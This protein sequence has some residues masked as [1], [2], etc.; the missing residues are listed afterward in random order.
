MLETKTL[1][2]EIE[3]VRGSKLGEI[4]KQVAIPLISILF[5]FILG[6]F[7]LMFLEYDPLVAYNKMTFKTL[8]EKRITTTLFYATPLIFTGLSVAVAFRAGMFN[9]GTE[10][11]MVIGAFF[12]ALVGFGLKNHFGIDFPDIIFILILFLAGFV[13]G[14]VWAIVPAVLKARGVHEVITTIMMNYIA[15]AL[16][17]FLVGSSESPF[18]DQGTV[19]TGNVSPQTPKIPTS[20]RLPLVF[21]RTFS[22]YLH[23]GFFIGLIVCVIIFIVMWKTKLG[24]EMRAVGYNPNAAKYGG[25]NV[26]K[27]LIIVML[28]SGGL[29]GLAGATEVIGQWFMYLDKSLAGYGFD[30]IA[31]AI[32]GGNH[33]F[34]VIFGALLFGWL[35]TAALVLQL[36]PNPI[37]KD[38][39][40]TLKGFIVLLVAVPMVSRIVIERLNIRYEGS[41][42]NNLVSSFNERYNQH[43]G[44]LQEYF[45][46]EYSPIKKI[47]YYG[48]LLFL[49]F[50]W[51]G[52]LLL[53]LNLF[54]QV[55]SWILLL[56]TLLSNN[57]ISN[58]LSTNDLSTVGFD[59]LGPI[60]IGLFSLVFV[61]FAYDFSK[62]KTTNPT[63]FLLL[64]F[65][66]FLVSFWLIF[67][68]ALILDIFYGGL[69]EIHTYLTIDLHSMQILTF[70]TE[71][72]SGLVIKLAELNWVLLTLL[73]S[74]VFVIVA[75]YLSRRESISRHIQ[76]FL[77]LS[78]K[79]LLSF[80]LIWVL[81]H[82]AIIVNNLFLHIFNFEII[83]IYSPELSN[84]IL[85]IERSNSLYLLVC[86]LLLLAGYIIILF[87]FIRKYRVISRIQDSFIF[88]LELISFIPSL[89]KKENIYI[90]SSFLFL[91]LTSFFAFLLLPL[92]HLSISS[93]FELAAIFLFL[94]SIS[95]LVFSFLLSSFFLSFLKEKIK[96]KDQIIFGTF[97][98][99]LG[100]SICLVLV[101]LPLYI[102]PKEVILL[103]SQYGTPVPGW[104]IEVD[105]YAR[106][107][108]FLE[109]IQISTYYNILPIQD[110]INS[111]LTDWGDF[112]PLVILT[113]IMIIIYRYSRTAFIT[114][115][116]V[117][118][119]IFAFV[120]VTELFGQDFAVIVAIL[121][122]GLFVISQE[123]LA[124]KSSLKRLITDRKT[125]EITKENTRLIGIY[126]IL[127]AMILIFLV[128]MILFG[129]T[130]LPLR[131]NLVF[132]WLYN[133]GA[134]IGII[135]L[136][137][138]LVGQIALFFSKKNL[139]P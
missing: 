88:F 98:I 65:L 50:I 2:E 43:K 82:T 27:N 116:C 133:Y 95:L 107:L 29:G 131:F 56:I 33:P 122:V 83:N 48:S 15:S 84:L 25:I 42:I 49:L 63:N 69:L 114:C 54:I 103:E 75:Y 130:H 51:G 104:G 81:L 76:G 72:A 14:A 41:W 68:A 132:F 79:I 85:I 16:L 13:G 138:I 113:V 96:D 117:G 128:L 10:G 111:I 46:V 35:Q 3:V 39:A 119:G 106:A 90:S 139:D 105:E 8:T 44:N 121:L 6:T 57:F 126:I 19:G 52:I 115:L 127:S 71:K 77:S 60:F 7:V 20:A 32:I 134:T 70:D 110:F 40:N 18:I 123:F 108:T 124:E 129:E 120:N 26:N 4:S 80:L 136:I 45:R 66:F 17:V 101:I 135:G 92:F 99:L 64:L 94:T 91:L 74:L 118:A 61:F 5:A 86:G 58:T 24:Y 47:L 137:I 87:F 21:D 102:L 112:L 100:L 125:V 31:V 62:K 93:L 36:P 109:W 12:S 22:R 11:Q 78:I 34:G 9:I 53:T 59:S 23:W 55:S 1:E 28:I 97:K 89:S 30:G 38:I 67:L 37:P 73:I